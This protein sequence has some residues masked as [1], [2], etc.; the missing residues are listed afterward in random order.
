PEVF[1]WVL[2][3]PLL[4][5]AAFAIEWT[6]FARVG[7]SVGVF[8]TV[9]VVISA[10]IASAVMLLVLHT[11]WPVAV[12]FGILVAATDP[13][14]VVA[15][16]HRANVAP[17]LR[18]FVESESLLNDGTVVVLGR[19]VALLV[20]SG[21]VSAAFVVSN[22]VSVS[23][24]SLFIGAAVGLAGTLLTSRVDDYLVEA[25]I[26]LVVAY[27]SF[28]LAQDLGLSGV[29]ATVA[30]GVVLGNIGRR[31]GMSAQ[32]REAVTLLWEFLAFV[33]NS[34]VFLLLGAAVI[35][36]RLWTILPDVLIGVL[37]ALLGRAVVTYGLGA[38]VAFLFVEPRLRWQSVLFWGG[39]RGALPVVV[40][41]DLAEQVD[42]PSL[43]SLVLGVV[44]VS[45]IVQGLTLD[46]MLRRVFS[47]RHT[48]VPKEFNAS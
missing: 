43:P 9:G 45:L 17:R 48:Q 27:G 38:V 1:L 34:F 31:F 41:L 11:P 35:P 7:I 10:A 4:F 19:V 47:E 26:S 16:F 24:G 12:L 30:A 6:E 20:A 44:F 18:T 3:P 36:G 5:E 25:T 42:A 32:T 14:A 22:F 15:L 23:V 2:L 13:V 28:A 37:A 40:A 29:L 39:L 21:S 33:A 46:P 8:A